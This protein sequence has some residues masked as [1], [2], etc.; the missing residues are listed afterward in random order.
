MPTFK[1][2]EKLRAVSIF[3]LTILLFSCSL[4]QTTVLAA[5]NSSSM[6]EHTEKKLDQNRGSRLLNGSADQSQKFNNAVK[7]FSPSPSEIRK[8]DSVIQSHPTKR[9]VPVDPNAPVSSFN[10][11][12]HYSEDGQVLPVR[13]P[14][15]QPQNPPQAATSAGEQ[16]TNQVNGITNWAPGY[17]SRLI[18]DN[19]HKDKSIRDKNLIGNIPATTELRS[20]AKLLTDSPAHSEPRSANWDQWYN[21][22]C[23]T[24]YKQWLLN[25]TGPGE[26]VLAVTAWP[27]RYVEGRILAFKTTSDLS[28]NLKQQEIFTEAALR[29]VNCLNRCAVLD[30]PDNS[31]RSR[32][33]FELA[34]KRAVGGASGFEVVKS[35]S[36]VQ[37]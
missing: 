31:S 5:D 20:T 35:S 14:S 19:Q 9:T 33:S 17:N 24:V 25:E 7:L 34:I 27:G 29:S 18:G 1:R 13:P 36:D 15:P 28:I 10:R 23:Q 32:V 16:T 11:I 21:N 30:F 8:P 26:A 2:N 3:Q 6:Q 22:V 37:F 12:K 4:N